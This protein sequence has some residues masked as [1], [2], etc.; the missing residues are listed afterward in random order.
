[1]SL[2]ERSFSDLSGAVLMGWCW[3]CTRCVSTFF[4]SGEGSRGLCSSPRID[5]VLPNRLKGFGLFF[6]ARFAEDEE[7]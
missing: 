2:N 4:L 5:L 3:A 6:F 7:V 1:M